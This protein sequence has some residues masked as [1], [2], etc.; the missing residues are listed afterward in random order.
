M[1]LAI[2]LWFGTKR[3]NEFE[4]SEDIF[5]SKIFENFESLCEIRRIEWN[6]SQVQMSQKWHIRGWNIQFFSLKDPFWDNALWRCILQH[7]QLMR[8]N[9]MA[10]MYTCW[11]QRAFWVWFQMDKDRLFRKQILDPKLSR[12]ISIFLKKSHILL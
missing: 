12:H 11:R 10:Q 6:M 1:L 8:T 3:R 4:I 5:F 9:K 2:Y 7:Y